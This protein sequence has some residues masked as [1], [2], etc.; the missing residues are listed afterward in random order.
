[1]FRKLKNI[2][3]WIFVLWKYDQPNE[4]NTLYPLI[5]Y[6]LQRFEEEMSLYNSVWRVGE[7][8][9]LHTCIKLLDQLIEDDFIK[10]EQE[11][12]DKKYGE[13]RL[14]QIGLSYSRAKTIEEKAL[15]S[16]EY[17]KLMH[18]EDS[19]RHQ[20]RLKL[21]MLLTNNIDKWWI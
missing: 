14:D 16:A 21:F 20:V 6:K 2:I 15:A 19:R 18:L 9:R 3:R 11:A 5:R 12:F 13:Y 10:V 8:E 7:Q 17:S 4:V 1:M